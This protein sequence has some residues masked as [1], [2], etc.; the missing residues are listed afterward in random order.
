VPPEQADRVYA[1]E[2]FHSPADGKL[3][4]P[5][6]KRTTNPRP[7]AN[8]LWAPEVQSVTF[9]PEFMAQ[10]KNGYQ[11]DTLHRLPGFA[12]FLTRNRRA[13]FWTDP[14]NRNRV[15]CE[16]DYMRQMM[17]QYRATYL[18]EI[19]EQQD[20]A[21]AYWT[22]LIGMN[23]SQHPNSFLLLNVALRTG[24]LVAMHYKN[25]FMRP[26]P[27]TLMPGLVPPFGP[28]GH[29]A[30]PSGHATQ[31]MLMSLCLTAATGWGSGRNRPSP[32][33]EELCWLARR[34][35]VNREVGGFHYPS[36]TVA[37]FFLAERTFELLLRGRRFREVLK[38]A[39]DE[40]DVPRND[41][42][43]LPGSRPPFC[44][45][46]ACPCEPKPARR[47]RRRGN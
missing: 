32:Y 27:S 3:D 15:E 20:R 39:N 21:P 42:V 46:Y 29:P 37:G 5:K 16:L 22:G 33:G 25:L 14:D 13:G 44:G 9:L 26:R 40:W 45:P 8:K 12:R 41:R 19:C 35:G 18:A 30:F 47:P 38:D 2:F 6:R 23:R 10:R 28:P 7:F 34:V 11:W 24:E 36:D 4:F 43:R 17:E 1:L 31:S